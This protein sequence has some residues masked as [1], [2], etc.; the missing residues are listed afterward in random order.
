MAN[1]KKEEGVDWV[2]VAEGAAAVAGAVGT[3]ISVLGG[4]GNSNLKS[5][6]IIQYT[7]KGRFMSR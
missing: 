4:K 5:A 6:T 7:I 3:L 2:K 1:N